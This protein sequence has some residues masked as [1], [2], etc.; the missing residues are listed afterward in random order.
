MEN[1][2]IVKI[3]EINPLM[4]EDL[5]CELR[6]YL[7]S[8]EK[9]YS[10]NSGVQGQFPAFL[11]NRTCVNSTR[12]LAIHTQFG[13]SN[14]AS[15]LVGSYDLA[16]LVVNNRSNSAVFTVDSGLNKHLAVEP[17]YELGEKYSF[18]N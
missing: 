15:G 8:E 1:K 14:G 13:P 18:K 6:S 4:L 2:K 7:N 17:L 12:V 10:Q 11:T 16:T 5:T 9:N 3:Y